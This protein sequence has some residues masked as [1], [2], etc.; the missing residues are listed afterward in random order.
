[1]ATSFNEALGRGY[2]VVYCLQV[3]GIPWLFVETKPFKIGADAVP[4][5][6]TYY[7]SGYGGGVTA[8][9][10]VD[11]EKVQQ[12]ID[13][14]QGISRARS[15]AFRLAYD[16]MSGAGILDDL[17]ARP[18][19]YSLLNADVDAAAT[20]FT[21]QQ[22]GGG[23]GT[24]SGG[25]YVGSEYL[26]SGNKTHSEPNTTFASLTRGHWGDK[27]DHYAKGFTGSQW[28][29]DRPHF[30][31]G[32]MVTLWECLVDP[33][34]RAVFTEWMAGDYCRQTFKGYLETNPLPVSEGFQIQAASMVRTATN[35]MGFKSDWKPKLQQV[36]KYSKTGAIENENPVDKK[37]FYTKQ[38]LYDSGEYRVGFSL[39]FSDGDSYSGEVGVDAGVY[40]HMG[41]WAFRVAEALCAATAHLENPGTISHDNALIG[42]EVVDDASGVQLDADSFA[43]TTEGTTPHF[44]LPNQEVLPAGNNGPV[45][46]FNGFALIGRWDWSD[47][48]CKPWLVLEQ[49]T[50]DTHQDYTLP[51][52]GLMVAELG[53]G[54]KELFTYTDGANVTTTASTEGVWVLRVKN[55][56]LNQKHIDLA[57]PEIKLTLVTGSD[58]PL[59]EVILTLLQSSGTGLRGDYDT[60][61]YGMGYNIDEAHI[62]IP[63]FLNMRY[64]WEEVMAVDDRRTSLKSALGGWIVAS[65]GC[66]TMR[67]NASGVLQLSHVGHE[68]FE[69]SSL[70]PSTKTI[71]AN[72]VL[73]EG[74]SPV[75]VV[76]SPNQIKIESKS[77]LSETD[78]P[79]I[80]VRSI[81]E[82]IRDGVHNWDL[83]C[84]DMKLEVANAAMQRLIAL[85]AGQYALSLV[86][87]PWVDIQE[88]DTCRLQL[89]GHLGTFN[90][91]TGVQ[92]T[93]DIPAR[94]M[95][96]SRDLV[97]MKQDCVFLLYAK[98]LPGN[99]YCPTL[100]VTAH[101]DG[102]KTLTLASGEGGW[103]RSADKMTIFNPGNEALGT[104]E[105]ATVTIA[106]ISGDVITITT[107]PPAWIVND[108]TR[109]TF[110][111]YGDATAAQREFFFYDATYRWN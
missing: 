4:D 12:E 46:T 81:P 50:A 26:W 95:G 22:T 75:D 74:V 100:T 35:E 68:I 40:A 94:C 90:F 97:T 52:A 59:S 96:V 60:L 16:P 106:S 10:I 31:R 83:S 63:S 107:T 47:H 70:D 14:E 72:D 89:S 66:L 82:I 93:T 77:Y 61:G 79:D 104:P 92:G 21:V 85:G 91:E 44:L 58:G 7:A 67:R 28:A 65:G 27:Y 43:Y 24:G 76:D 64:S 54:E 49:H 108:T 53:D 13:R 99:M 86:V 20:N 80:I 57:H 71:T 19:L 88:G 32:R 15:V 6:P 111:K 101:N 110:P 17:F 11:G 51:T 23:W 2:S 5:E 103:Y 48:H 98:T 30:W 3:E 55:R 33:E 18:T 78:R 56:G 38:M 84:P 62:D 45:E 39:E 37:I 69:F 102:A 87:G 41:S 1:M 29:T 109:A 42:F 34:G 8:G 73:I 36:G 25:L 105:L 9:L